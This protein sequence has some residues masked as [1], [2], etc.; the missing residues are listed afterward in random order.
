MDV[1]F[2]NYINLAYRVSYVNCSAAKYMLMEAPKLRDFSYDA[3]L[4]CCFTWD[5]TPQGHAFWSNIHKS[6]QY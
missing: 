4:M 5:E 3:D 2:R 1:D 6:I